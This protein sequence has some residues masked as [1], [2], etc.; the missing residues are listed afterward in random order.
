[1]IKGKTAEVE[2]LERR[3]TEET[4]A[5]DTLGSELLRAKSAL[6]ERER[7]LL[8]LRKR[9]PAKEKEE[10]GKEAR[11]LREKLTRAEEELRVKEIREK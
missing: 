10:D 9:K 8:E 11:E 7:E 5:K 1:M 4:R 6:D 2:A 3:L